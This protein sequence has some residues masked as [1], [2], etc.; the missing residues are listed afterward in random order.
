MPDLPI[1]KKAQVISISMPRQ[2]LNKLDALVAHHGYTGRS[3]LIRDA[4]RDLLEESELAQNDQTPVATTITVV[5]NHGH[6]GVDEKLI[7]LRHEYDNLVTGNIHL[8]IKGKYCLEIFVAE[9]TQSMI[10]TLIGRIRATRGILSVKYAT[11]PLIAE[12]F[13]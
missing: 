11:V 12:E 13:M 3:E 6:P 10:I 1:E 9:G 7:R 2:F 8:H 5:Y 4:V